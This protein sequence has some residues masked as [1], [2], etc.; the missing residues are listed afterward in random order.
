MCDNDSIKDIVEYN[1]RTGGLSRREFSAL[2]LGAGLMS[3]LP[4]AAAAVETKDS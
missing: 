4:A 2:T 3:A 1:R